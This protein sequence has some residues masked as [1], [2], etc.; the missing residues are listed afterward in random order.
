M[1]SIK[2]QIVGCGCVTLIILIF[3][4]ISFF[5][6]GYFG[7]DFSEFVKGKSVQVYESV[8]SKAKDVGE[9]VKDAGAE[10]VDEASKKGSDAVVENVEENVKKKVQEGVDKYVEEK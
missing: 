10:I 2:D 5:I 4:I 3:C 8:V 9:E 7:E 6:G 1:S